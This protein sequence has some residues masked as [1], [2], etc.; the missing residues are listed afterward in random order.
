MK[1]QDLII[2]LHSSIH[3][4][5]SNEND[6]KI[7]KACELISVSNDIHFDI[8]EVASAVNMGYENF[9][10]FFKETTGISLSDTTL[11]I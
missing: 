1:S 4:A 2:R 5:H 3:N 8:Q 10:K 6:S 7:T 11:N 9:R